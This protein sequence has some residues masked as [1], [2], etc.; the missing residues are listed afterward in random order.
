MLE[1][2]D[3]KFT[4]KN[5]K[6]EWRNQKWH[7]ISDIDVKNYGKLF[8]IIY[9]I[10]NNKTCQK[11]VGL[12]VNTPKNNLKKRLNLHKNSAE[13]DK[14]HPLSQAIYEYGG[15]EAFTVVIIDYAFNK[16]ELG[17][18]EIYHIDKWQVLDHKFGYNIR[19]GG[20]YGKLA[21]KTINKIKNFWNDKNK[22]EQ[23]KRKIEYYKNPK[24]REEQSKRANKLYKKHP[25]IVENNSKAHI[26]LWEEGSE[27]RKKQKK[28]RNTFEYKENQSKKQIE[29]EI[30]KK[31]DFIIQ[32]NISE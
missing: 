24:N 14:D 18:K 15:I 31:I 9:L 19:D 1:S 13:N 16:D 26:K 2:E 3:Q 20:Y 6:I 28:T 7:I 10:I 8:G 22:E 25:E 5:P 11:Y 4:D 29:I 17:A 30:Q 23:S 32:N 21:K 27:Y 12:V